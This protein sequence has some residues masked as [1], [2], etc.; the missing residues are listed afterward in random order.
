[1]AEA[2]IGINIT[3]STA[4]IN[5]ALNRL[6][7]QLKRTATTADVTGKKIRTMGASMN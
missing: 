3:G 1:M 2:T 7:G 6:S 5:A 4:S